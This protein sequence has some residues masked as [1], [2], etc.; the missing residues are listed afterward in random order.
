[1]EELFDAHFDVGNKRFTYR[2]NPEQAGEIYQRI[3]QFLATGEGSE[4]LDL[5]FGTTNR[6]GE[7]VQQVFCVDTSDAFILYRRL[8]TYLQKRYPGSE[9]Q[10]RL[11]EAI[12]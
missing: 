2:L 8:G 12:S 1:M 9:P 3:G 7:D 6:F 11:H 5:T 10:F 4:G